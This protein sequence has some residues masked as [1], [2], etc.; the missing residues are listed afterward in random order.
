MPLSKAKQA[1]WMREYRRRVKQGSVIPKSG[2]VIPD[3]VVQPNV[4]LQPMAVQP[5]SMLPEPSRVIPKSGSVI[6]KSGGVIP[7]WNNR[8][9]TIEE[10][11]KRLY[12]KLPNSPDGRYREY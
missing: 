1:E 8:F 9:E 10:Q 11:M 7:K 6:P 12:G 5:K 2:S 3:W 4:Y